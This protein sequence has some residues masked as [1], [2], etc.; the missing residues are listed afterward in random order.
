MELDGLEF[1]TQFGCILENHLPPPSL[2]FIFWNMGLGDH[3]EREDAYK[4]SSELG[5]EG[6][7]GTR[8]RDYCCFLP[9]VA[10][11]FLVLELRFA[12]SLSLARR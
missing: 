10:D 9:S 3:V 2:N 8:C 1:E 11:D 12:G 5:T 7:P 6:T 4:T